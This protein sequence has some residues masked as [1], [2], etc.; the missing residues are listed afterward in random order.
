MVLLFLYTQVY[1]DMET[2]G[3][4]YTVFQRRKDGSADFFR[5]FLDYE[6]SFG[7]LN[8]VFLLLGL[9]TIYHLIQGMDYYTLRV[10]LQDFDNEA[11]YAKYAKFCLGD[12][13]LDNPVRLLL[14]K[15]IP[16]LQEIR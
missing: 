15:D 5:N 2:D 13:T 3:G 11:R 14:W 1:C 10:D 6:E 7:D 12:G 8:G 16:V 9:K 4:G